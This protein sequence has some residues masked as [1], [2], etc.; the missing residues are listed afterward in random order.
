[1]LL[2][3]SGALRNYN[4]MMRIGENQLKYFV[5]DQWRDFHSRMTSHLL[6][7]FPNDLSSEQALELAR[8]AIEQAQLLEVDTEY[9]MCLLAHLIHA[10]CDGAGLK[11]GQPPASESQS[12]LTYSEIEALHAR[13]FAS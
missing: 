12:L 8:C 10:G 4:G 13:T 1:M 7:V 9:H 11:L 6:E 3:P 5:A 2:A